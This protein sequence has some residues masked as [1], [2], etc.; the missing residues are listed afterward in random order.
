LET[1]VIFSSSSRVHKEAGTLLC[2]FGKYA[3]NFWTPSMHQIQPYLQK[4]TLFCSVERFVSDPFSIHR[5]EILTDLMRS[6]RSKWLESVWKSAAISALPCH[7]NS[8]VIQP[9]VTHSSV[10]FLMTLPYH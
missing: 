8:W 7:S 4:L 1:L 9:L 3:C 10:L 5:A 6:S 2:D